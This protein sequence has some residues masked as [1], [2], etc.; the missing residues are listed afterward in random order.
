MFNLYGITEVS[1]WASCQHIALST[2]GCSEPATATA[3]A[4]A[5]ETRPAGRQVPLGE[6]LLGT[7]IELR[8]EDGSKITHGFGEIWIGKHIVVCYTCTLQSHVSVLRSNE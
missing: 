6:P 2:G 8:T 4:T 3:A 5:A 7:A 1:S